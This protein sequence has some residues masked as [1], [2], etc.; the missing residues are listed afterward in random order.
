MTHEHRPF[1]I[2]KMKK[3]PSER[4]DAVDIKVTH[5]HTI[6]LKRY[7]N[8]VVEESKIVNGT[9]EI[10]LQATSTSLCSIIAALY[11]ISLDT[12]I[13]MASTEIG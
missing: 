7:K 9:K 2:D 5:I 3:D 1:I 8:E 6:R 11:M 12:I 10:H 13:N 4:S